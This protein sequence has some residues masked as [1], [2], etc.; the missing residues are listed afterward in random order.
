MWHQ[1]ASVAN[2]CTQNTNISSIFFILFRDIDRSANSATIN[3]ISEEKKKIVRSDWGCTWKHIQTDS[4]LFWM[5]IYAFK[6]FEICLFFSFDLFCQLQHYFSTVHF[7]MCTQITCQRRLIAFARLFSTVRFQMGR[8]IARVW[9]DWLRLFQF[10]FS[11]M[12]VFKWVFKLP[13]RDEA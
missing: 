6:S 13:A 11:P 1:F 5:Y 9:S 7:Q 12:C 3:L 4:L 10:H 2:L 8:Q